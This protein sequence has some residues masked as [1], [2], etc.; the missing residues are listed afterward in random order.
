MFIYG[1]LSGL[2]TIIFIKKYAKFMLNI[3]GFDKKSEIIDDEISY[4]RH[5]MSD[6]DSDYEDSDTDSESFFEYEEEMP[7][8]M[9]DFYEETTLTHEWLKKSDAEKKKIL[10]DD[11]DNYMKN[12]QREIVKDHLKNI[13]C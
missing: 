8:Y 4:G 2:M 9:E 12:T 7:C 3:F 13:K 6:S 1:I 5:P 10:D 11:I